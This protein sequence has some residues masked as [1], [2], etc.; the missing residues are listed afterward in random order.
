MGGGGRTLSE[1]PKRINKNSK[2]LEPTCLG[3]LFS[4]WGLL[5]LLLKVIELWSLCSKETRHFWTKP[6]SPNAPASYPLPSQVQTVKKLI[7]ILSVCFFFLLGH[8]SI[9]QWKKLRL[10]EGVLLHEDKASQG[11]KCKASNVSSVS[12]ASSLLMFLPIPI[13]T[14]LGH[15]E[16]IQKHTQRH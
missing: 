5:L 11:H 10:R 16:H 14:V 12:L 4:N 1:I 9:L 3:R 15:V 2:C 7:L 8:A 6:A 13:G